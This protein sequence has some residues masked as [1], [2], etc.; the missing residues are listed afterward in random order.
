M[1]VI[2]AG[3]ALRSMYKIIKHFKIANFH[4]FKF[5]Y[6]NKFKHKVQ[7]NM[8]ERFNVLDKNLENLECRLRSTPRQ[9]IVVGFV[10]DA[11]AYKAV[12][13]KPAISHAL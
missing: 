12:L 11:L 7:Q 4:I 9:V 2:F 1:G 8:L 6:A 5:N 3:F 13:A 10:L